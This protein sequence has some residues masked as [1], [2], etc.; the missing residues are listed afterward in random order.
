MLRAELHSR[1]LGVFIC[2][3]LGRRELGGREGTFGGP[4]PPPHCHRQAQLQIRGGC[5]SQ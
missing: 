1:E 2:P 3:V 5:L 4:E